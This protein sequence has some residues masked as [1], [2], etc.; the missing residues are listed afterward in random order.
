MLA[1]IQVETTPDLSHFF[2][3]FIVLLFAQINEIEQGI[4][5]PTDLKFLFHALTVVS[6]A[7]PVVLLAA[8]NVSAR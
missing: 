2:L 8:V 6:S 1:R 3:M 4:N 7:T 5:P